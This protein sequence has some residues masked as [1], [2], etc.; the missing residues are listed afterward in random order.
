MNSPSI[1]LLNYSPQDIMQQA[2]EDNYAVDVSGDGYVGKI[3][4]GC[5]ISMDNESEEVLIQSTTMGGE[6]YKE[7]PADIYE[8]FLINGWRIGV[9]ELSLSNYRI[10][11]DRIEQSIKTEVNGRKNPKQIQS[12]KASRESVLKRYSKIKY[13]LNQISNGKI[14]NSQHQR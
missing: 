2:I 4:F 10:K 1:N 9:Y 5:K 14:K 7:V 6:Y 8:T 11:L 12:L 3:L 13:K